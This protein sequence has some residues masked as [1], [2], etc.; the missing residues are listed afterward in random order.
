MGDCGKGVVP[1]A[2]DGSSDE[3]TPTVIRLGAV[4]PYR[5]G[6]CDN[7]DKGCE[8]VREYGRCVNKFQPWIQC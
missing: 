5:G 1:P 3:T 6:G 8:Y 7:R 4:N 2:E